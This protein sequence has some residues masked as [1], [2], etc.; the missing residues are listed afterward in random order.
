MASRVRGLTSACMMVAGLVVVQSMPAKASGSAVVLT[1]SASSVAPG[2]QVTLTAATPVAGVGTISQEI[3]QTI[4]PTKLKLTSLDDITYPTG[5]SLSFSTD[6]TTFSSAVPANAAAWAAVRAVKA[7][8]AVVSQGDS[9]GKQIAVG[10]STQPLVPPGGSFTATSPGS[11][12][13]IVAFDDDGRVFIQVHH[14]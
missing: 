13:W 9:N 6:G 10:S 8:G 5:W 3:V 14:K 2:S 7:S 12:P 11:D 4:D 1:P